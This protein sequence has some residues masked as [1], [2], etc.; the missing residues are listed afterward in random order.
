MNIIKAI[1]KEK[2]V[3]LVT[4]ETS[5]AN[6]YASRIIQIKDGKVEKDYANNTSEELDYRVDNKIYLKDFKNAEKIK[7]NNIKI[8]VYSDD[9]SKI[10]IK[11]IVK[12]GN[13]YIRSEEDK[14]EIVDENS[15]IELVD[16]HYKKIDKKNLK[17]YEYNLENIVDK[18]F[19]PKY[20]SINSLFKSVIGG[21]KKIGD[22]SVLKKILLVGFFASSMFIVYSVCNIKGT[23]NIEDRRFYDN[24]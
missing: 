16:A 22:F 11:L 6:F 24:G 21:F 1:S 13:I 10:N 19:I 8:D 4:H 3:I 5:L 23:L 18:D 12:N 14:V 17:E 20:S 7:S 2:L 15:G 9:T